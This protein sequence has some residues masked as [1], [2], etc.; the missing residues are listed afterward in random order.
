MT[1]VTTKRLKLEKEIF[2]EIQFTFRFPEDLER[3]YPNERV[4]YPINKS[5]IHKL[6][7]FFFLLFLRYIC[8]FFSRCK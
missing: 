3:F 8:R 7:K 2:H 6:T 5:F 1:S 4:S